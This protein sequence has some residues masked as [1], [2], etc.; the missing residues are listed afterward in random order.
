[1][2]KLI[3]EHRTFRLTDP[4]EA[5]R[6]INTPFVRWFVRASLV[7]VLVV[8]IGAL[9]LPPMPGMR[10]RALA[11][12]SL[13]DHRVYAIGIQNYFA[14][15]NDQGLVSDDPMDLMPYMIDGADSVYVEELLYSPYRGQE[16]GEDVP[17]DYVLNPDLVAREL[18]SIEYPSR[19]IVAL[20]VYVLELERSRIVVALADG[21]VMAIERAELG[22][23][24]S[25]PWHDFL[26]EVIEARSGIAVPGP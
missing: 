11:I 7:I 18:V 9:L 24:L 2:G 13:S 20:D 21:S 1:M 19:T 5:S 8:F 26:R 23:L 6:R 14:S 25:E 12:R 16:I 17:S 10:E 22:L 15:N 3:S 4:Q